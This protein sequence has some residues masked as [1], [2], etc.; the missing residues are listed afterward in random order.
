MYEF[1]KKYRT[2]CD[3]LLMDDVQFL[4]GKD[5]TQEEFFHT[6]NTLHESKR[7]IVMTADKLPKDIK[8]LEE[9]LKSRFEW[10]LIADI[11]PPE[12]ETR[13]AILRKKAFQNNFEVNDD[14]AMFIAT[15][16]ASNIRELEV[17]L[18]RVKAYASL[19][20]EKDMTLELCKR[21]LKDFINHEQKKISIDDIQKEVCRF[22]NIK[23]SDIKS[24]SR[25]KSLTAPRQVAMFLSRKLTQSSFPMISKEFLKK[26]HTTIIHAVKKVEKDMAINQE[27]KEK[28]SQIE[29][30]IYKEVTQ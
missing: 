27:L 22:Y 2:D 8:L 6:F 10:G 5:R 16:A 28:V 29:R 26:D 17:H 3:V 11:E 9:R 7:Q 13:I 21:A 1:R 12:I 23:L 19:M 24:E 18:I 4:G 14:V 20:G 30:N 25:I 15:N